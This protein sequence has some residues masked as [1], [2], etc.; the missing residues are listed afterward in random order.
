MTS[1]RILIV[2]LLVLLVAAAWTMR[3]A[4]R[5]P[6]AWL[7]E[8]YIGSDSCA[9]CHTLN[10]PTWK[11]TL[12]A[13]MVQ[14]ASPETIRGDFIDD[15][16]YWLR[17]GQWDGS[18]P[19]DDR[20]LI[21]LERYEDEFYSHIFDPSTGRMNP[22]RISHVVG[23]EFRQTYLIESEGTYFRMPIQW[24]MK[25]RRWLNLWNRQE[26]IPETVGGPMEQLTNEN[27]HWNLACARCHTT[28][29]E[30]EGKGRWNELGIAC[31]SCHGPGGAHAEQYR[32]SVRLRIR[33]E[34][35]RFLGRKHES[36]VIRP[37][38][39]DPA[40][41]VS[42]CAQCHHADTW[43]ETIAELVA[44]EPGDDLSSTFSE[45]PLARNTQRPPS[46][47][48]WP[49]GSPRGPGMLF[50]SFVESRCFHEGGATCIDC[51]SPHVAGEFR[52]RLEPGNG[53]DD[54]CLACHEELRPDIAAHTHHKPEGEGSRCM[55]CH[56][57]KTLEGIT[58]VGDFDY[59]RVRSH[60]IDHIPFPEASV[61]LGGV[62]RM[63]NA[64]ADCHADE[65]AEW[66]ARWSTEWWGPRERIAAE[67]AARPEAG[68][69]PQAERSLGL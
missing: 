61:Q 19:A 68:A 25:G 14:V 36:Y 29:Y 33:S 37:S 65:S 54:Y 21:R 57:P 31:E 40:G 55:G 45:V 35:L 27:A 24:D 46:N 17:H 63:P 50:R 11:E 4:F 3:Q 20:P 16:E 23:T 52:G 60:E 2:G 30:M 51:H 7:E 5:K 38:R 41:S 12:H 13:S 10:H 9:E 18:V 48:T 26:R 39:L 62:E 28:G 32:N 8:T 42:V 53:S 69:S 66:A 67:I 6:P 22:Y 64:C 58:F 44:Y 34:V 56:M 1:K 49:D 59:A 43:K 15:N 47:K